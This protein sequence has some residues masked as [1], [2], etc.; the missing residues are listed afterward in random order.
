LNILDDF[1]TDIYSIT[2]RYCGYNFTI[3][4]EGLFESEAPKDIFE[5]FIWD[6][7]INKLFLGIRVN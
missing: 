4:S 2:I 6:E 5:R 3:T 1:D 7:I